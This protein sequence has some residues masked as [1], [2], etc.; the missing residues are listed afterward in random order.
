M[1]RTHLWPRDFSQHSRQKWLHKKRTMQ[2][3]TQLVQTKNWMFIS[4]SGNFFQDRVWTLDALFAIILKNRPRMFH[5]LQRRRLWFKSN[6]G[7]QKSDLNCQDSNRIFPWDFLHWK[8]CSSNHIFSH[9]QMQFNCI[10]PVE[11]SDWSQGA[12]LRSDLAKLS[13]VELQT[14]RTSST[15]LPLKTRWPGSWSDFGYIFF[16]EVTLARVCW[17]DCLFSSPDSI[18]CCEVSSTTWIFQHRAG[19]AA[20][21]SYEQFLVFN[22]FQANSS[23]SRLSPVFNPKTF[24]GTRPLL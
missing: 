11:K 3:H 9:K 8:K 19:L 21:D 17:T 13:T 4:C 23:C 14:P 5:H 10:Y 22:F 6:C 16:F 20:S 18:L 1:L 15:L 7:G 24:F 12:P 2:Y